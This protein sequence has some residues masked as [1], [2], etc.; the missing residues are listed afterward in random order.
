[1]GKSNGDHP[2]SYS[3]FTKKDVVLLGIKRRFKHLFP[4]ATPQEPSDWLKT[5]IEEAPSGQLGSEKA[6]SEF[7]IAPV[8]N[9]I[10]RRNRDK[11]AVFSGYTFEVEPP[12]GLT[13]SC[14]FLFS[15]EVASPDIEAPIFCVFEAKN[16]NIES[17]IPQ[18]LATMYAARLFNERQGQNT[19]RIFG[20]VTYGKEWLFLQL[21]GD[22]GYQDTT[23]YFLNDLPTLLGVLQTIVDQFD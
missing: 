14:D 5:T 16:E 20:A 21:E 2:A 23:T 6:K 13:G 4:N 11:V 9:E 17:G 12:L 7:L 19:R 22:T 15:K 18:C 10:R 3:K 8:L 1:M